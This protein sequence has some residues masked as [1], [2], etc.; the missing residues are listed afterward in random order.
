LSEILNPLRLVPFIPPMPLALVLRG[1]L[2]EG[3]PP[4]NTTGKS[5]VWPGAVE[6]VANMHPSANR[7][8]VSCLTFICR[9]VPKK[10]PDGAGPHPRRVEARLLTPNANFKR[11]HLPNS[12]GTSGHQEG[13]VP[14]LWLELRSGSFK[15]MYKDKV[16]SAGGW[17]LIRRRLSPKGEAAN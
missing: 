11:D 16:Q 4:R 7:T 10:A 3:S 17:T 1:V 9:F 5:A 12:K 15:L 2:R 8:P 13:P 14:K 6:G